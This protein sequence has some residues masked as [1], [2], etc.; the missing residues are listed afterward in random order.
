MDKSEGKTPLVRTGISLSEVRD[1]EETYLSRR[2]Q[3][4]GVRKQSAIG[5]ALSG[6]GVRSAC[7]ALGVINWMERS[8]QWERIDYVS[9]VSG[10]GYA[11][12]AVL[13]I[14]TGGEE[15]ADDVTMAET[16]LAELNHDDE[17][18]IRFSLLTMLAM[19][20]L[21]IVSMVLSL[22]PLLLLVGQSG[23]LV[24]D[25]FPTLRAFDLYVSGIGGVIFLLIGICQLAL[26]RFGKR[27]APVG[28]PWFF[29]ATMFFAI[30]VAC[31]AGHPQS[32]QRQP[33][34]LTGVP[35]IATCVVA[36]LIWVIVGV[37]LSI[38]P[39]LPAITRLHR[40]A[41]Y[42]LAFA[43]ILSGGLLME[44]VMRGL[45]RHAVAV[46][47][48][49]IYWLSMLTV[50]AAM[51]A[52]PNWF[53]LTVRI[54]YEGLLR[55][56]G[57]GMD[58]PVHFAGGCRE[59]PIHLINCFSQ[60]PV[61]R[62]DEKKQRRGGE[63]FCVSHRY[64][65]THSGGYFPTKEWYVGNRKKRWEHQRIWRLAATSGA[66]FDIH[67]VRQSPLWNSLLTV[68][69]MGLGV[70]VINPAFDPERRAW[71]PTF[72]LNF[73]AALGVHNN[74]TKWMR[75]SDGGHFENL[76]IYE[77]IAR[78]CTDIVVVDAGHDPNYEF[79]DLAYA[80]ERCRDDFSAVIDIPDFFPRET[81]NGI[82]KVI[83]TG[84]VRYKD[85]PQL[86]KLTY[87]KLGVE[88]WHS[89]PLRLRSSIDRH[90]PHEPTTNQ[91]PTRDFIN[92]YYRLGE[93]TATQALPR[94]DD[95]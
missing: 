56:F 40:G 82:Q 50:F 67:P 62:D 66:A 60:S 5:L 16:V 27:P 3:S 74:R 31:W 6:G 36:V 19:I 81:R 89:L 86:G 43:A 22:A 77:L 32:G 25:S 94:A 17:G 12:S 71:R 83:L 29:L 59:A 10:G 92:A 49:F 61:A 34:E 8:G 63:N 45:T 23:P 26:S 9:S 68:F 46:E 73:M 70:W 57:R 95:S 54:Y 1:C 52:N 37:A 28:Q 51:L 7:F 80:I 13:G 79:A 35:Y 14:Q 42:A 41:R 15:K 90:F 85:K 78:E 76:G 72:F 30:Q 69:N 48:N 24:M 87:I 47:L 64:C 33:I 2:R 53:C 55:K 84:T 93:E 65:G 21:W 58:Q 39:R 38:R 88:S 44:V 18:Y 20:A 4:V 75:L 11:A 91:F